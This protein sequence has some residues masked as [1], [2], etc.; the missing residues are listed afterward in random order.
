MV[1]PISTHKTRWIMPRL[2]VLPMFSHVRLMSRSLRFSVIATAVLA[3][4]CGEATTPT[5]PNAV[6]LVQ[7]FSNLTTGS[8]TTVGASTFTVPAGVTSL[9]I[10]AVGG[11]GGGSIYMPGGSGARVTS[12]V[13][14]TPG[15]VLD[16]FVGSGTSG[17]N[18]NVPGGGSSNIISGGT[19]LVIAGGGG[20]GGQWGAGGSAGGPGGAGAQGASGNSGSYSGTGGKGGAGGIGGLGGVGTCQYPPL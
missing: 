17:T 18:W 5:Q 10:V 16:L 11:G 12:T 15:Q 8:Y 19:P 1:R 3:A 6:A 4:A 7:G 9:E 14:V 2:A 20:G 13:A